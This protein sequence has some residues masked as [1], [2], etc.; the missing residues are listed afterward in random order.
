[1]NSELQTQLYN[2]NQFNNDNVYDN[3]NISRTII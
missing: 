3:N 2:K 1:M